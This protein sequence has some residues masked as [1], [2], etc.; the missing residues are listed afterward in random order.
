MASGDTKT[1]AMLNVLGNGGTGDEFR[2]CC[3][4][5]TQSYILDA[6]DR[7]NAIQPG[8]SSDFN[9][10]SNRPQLN[11]TAM[12]G[13][14]NITNFTGT[15]G[16]NAGAQGLVPAPAATDADKFLKSD[17]TWATAGGGGPT[18]VQSIGNS[19]TDVMSQKATSYMIY[20]NP[21]QP[22]RVRISSTLDNLGDSAVAIGWNAMAFGDCALALGASAVS[23]VNRGIA[24]GYGAYGGNRSVAIGNNSNVTQNNY[25]V[26][27][28]AGAECSRDGEI[29]VGN[30]VYPTSGYNNT[31]Y[32]VIGGVHDAVDN[33]DAVTLGQINTLVTL[34]NT[35]LNTNIV[36]NDGVISDGNSNNA[37]QNSGNSGSSAPAPTPTY[38]YYEGTHA[39]YLY[40]G[41]EVYY[42][43]TSP[44]QDL[45][46]RDGTLA[47]AE[48]DWCENEGQGTVYYC[49]GGGGEEEPAEPGDM[50]GP[51][52]ESVEG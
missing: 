9:D 36:I 48:A 7:I 31:A 26:A 2:G 13:N 29:Y 41:Q 30:S 12:T 22:S 43:E 33:H 11:G 47:M 16:T 8:G 51:E 15:D 40:N 4:T 17:G 10:L 1:E 5:K 32:R 14:T 42:D 52:D 23:N 45:Y 27:L 38:P 19:Q 3:N 44:I 46:Y 37:N 24:I 21:S 49:G 6:I 34:I 50:P 35:L 18:V 39:F 28:G 20:P 25:S